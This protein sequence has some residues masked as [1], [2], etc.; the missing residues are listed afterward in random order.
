[1]S[2]FTRYAVAICVLLLLLWSVAIKGRNTLDPLHFFDRDREFPCIHTPHDV[3]I[4]AS[5][6]AAAAGVFLDLRRAKQKGRIASLSYILC[7]TGLFWMT[8]SL[9]LFF[10]VGVA[11]MCGGG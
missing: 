5:V 2:R 7:L 4:I 9:L 6:L 11:F 1:M 10:I 3:A 8:G